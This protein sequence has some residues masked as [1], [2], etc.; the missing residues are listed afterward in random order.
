MLRKINWKI[1]AG[2]MM[3]LLSIVFYVLHYLI[4]H[5][6]HHIFLYLIGDIAFVFIEVLMVTLIIHHLLNEWEKRS[7]LRK[8]NMVIETFFSEFGKHLLVYL[9]NYDKNLDTVKNAITDQ[10]KCCELDFKAAFKA[11]KTYKADIDIQRMDL[12]KLSEFLTQRRSFL[13]NL[14]QNPNLLEH[15]TFTNTLM[16]IFHI[17]EELAARDL[18]AL[19]EDDKKHTKVDIE[20]AYNNLTQQWLNYMRYTQEHFPYFFL[21]AMQTNPFDEK[22]SWLERWYE[23]LPAS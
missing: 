9:S 23:S 5:D 1:F 6:A 16:S 13:I 21:F 12:K 2:I 3:V 18:T 14:L 7:H 11:L 17:A 15:E 20:R 8:L 19:S 4:F 22:A 10:N